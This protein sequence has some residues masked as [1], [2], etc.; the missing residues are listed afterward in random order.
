MITSPRNPHIRSLRTLSRR[1]ER[2]RQRRIV[3]SGVRLIDAALRF[4]ARVE[5]LLI[6]PDA[7]GLADLRERAA[8]AGA[9][10][11]PVSERV[12][13]ALADVETPQPVAAVVG[14]PEPV[15]LAEVRWS[16]LVVADG[17]QD[18]GNLG[19]LIRT[20]HAAGFD[21]VAVTEG[22]VD[23]FTSKAIRASAGSCFAIPIGRVSPEAVPSDAHVWVADGEGGYDY[24][25]VR[26]EPPLVLVF[27]GEGSGPARAWP[28]ARRVR[29][30]I[31][32]GVE[33]LNVAAAAAILLFAAKEPVES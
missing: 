25:R 6:V 26:F 11:T 9:T 18:P 29:I 8:A 22:T 23:P 20:A 10:V 19:T 17:L 5:E 28:A 31:R 16:W 1:R 21:A 15:P 2:G 27:G 33:S 3:V 24:R 4:G 7:D 30:P 13:R 12:I 32:A 14:L